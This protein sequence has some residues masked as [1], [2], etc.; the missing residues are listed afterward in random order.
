MSRR[1]DFLAVNVA[2]LTLSLLSGPPGPGEEALAAAQKSALKR[3]RAGRTP[4]TESEELIVLVSQLAYARQVPEIEPAM[5][6][7][8]VMNG[9]AALSESDSLDQPERELARALLEGR[10]LVGTE[11]SQGWNAYAWVGIKELP[12]FEKLV[13]HALAHWK[14]SAETQLAWIRQVRDHA[15]PVDIFLRVG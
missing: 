12:T 9:I 8:D 7:G 6:W 4:D 3:L 13:E 1:A 5:D 14:V 11:M 15:P 10:P 2:Q